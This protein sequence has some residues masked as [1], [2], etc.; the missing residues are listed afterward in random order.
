[1]TKE[2]NDH[3]K[4]E[5]PEEFDPIEEGVVLPAEY[6]P[7]HPGWLSISGIMKISDPVFEK[8]MFLIGY[9][10]SS[11]VY[12]LAGDYLTIVDPGNDYTVFTELERLGF[13]PLDIKKVVVT[14]GHRDHCMGVFELLRF[15]PIYEN[16]QIEIVN[17]EGGPLEFKKILEEQGFSLTQVKGGETLELSGFEWEVIHTP[18]HTIDSICLYN[19]ATKTAITGDTVLPHAM[20]EVDKNAGGRLDHYLYG[21]KQLLKKDIDNIL[22]GHGVPVAGDGRIAV[23]QTYEGVMMKVAEIEPESKTTWMEGATLLAEKGLLEEVVYCCDKELALK[24]DKL[25]S[26]QLKAFAL[27]DMGRCE[28]AI[29]ILDQILAKQGENVH[30]LTA[31]GHALLGLQKFDE[32]IKYFDQALAIDP[33][34]KEAQ[35]FKGMALYFMGKY[36]EAMDIEP[37]RVEFMYR[38]K[39]EIDKRQEEKKQDDNEPGGEDTNEG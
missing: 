30:A 6:E 13:N 10:E 4:F 7:D 21:L 28:E 11:N 38:F 36:D 32:S 14:H 34:I 23:E 18:G 3:G 1:M 31:R 27:N 25:S 29:E 35:V 2:K 15:P 20:A 37:F 5:F 8:S 9:G 17:H 16:K 24:P 22:P 33:E 19:E 39:D 26:L 12:V